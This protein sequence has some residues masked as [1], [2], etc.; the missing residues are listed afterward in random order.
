MACGIFDISVNNTRVALVRLSAEGLIE[1]AG[2]ALYQLSADAHRLADDV[3]SWRNR[4]QNLRPWQGDYV[5]IKTGKLHRSESKAKKARER[6]LLMTG[7]RP[8]QPDFFIRPNNIEESIPALRQR[9]Y[10][11]GLEPEAMIF[12]ANEFS[13]DIQQDLLK[14]WQPTQLVKV[15]DQLSEKMTTWLA[16]HTELEAE[17]AARESFLLGGSAIK[18][19]VYDPFLPPQWIDTQKRERFIDLVHQVD[20]AGKSIWQALWQASVEPPEVS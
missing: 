18:H 14:L 3:A 16:R 20:S 11:L 2:R 19:V 15:Y 5:A 1:S 10:T 6:A 4:S 12:Q 17:V 8:L 7:F 13:E 9:L